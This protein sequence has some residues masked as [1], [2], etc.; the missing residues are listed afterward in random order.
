MESAERR[1]M[2][3]FEMKCLRC[4]GGVT[5]MDRVRNEKVH[6]IAGIEGSCRVEWITA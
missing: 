5:R 1:K 6:R 4:L 2:D 3:V